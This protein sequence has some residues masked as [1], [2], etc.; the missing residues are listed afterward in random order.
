MSAFPLDSLVRDKEL[1][2]Y[3]HNF[4]EHR[5]GVLAFTHQILDTAL[6]KLEIAPRSRVAIDLGVRTFEVLAG[7]ELAGDVSK[8]EV[9]NFIFDPEKNGNFLI[10]LIESINLAGARLNDTSPELAEASERL[11]K[12]YIDDPTPDLIVGAWSG[13][14]IM[15]E[16]FTETYL[17]TVIGELPQSE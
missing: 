9:S 15:N 7:P 16:I 10:D 6:V 2:D 3:A 14:G 5:I 1:F 12:A 13:A 17:G 11:V 4:V 8:I